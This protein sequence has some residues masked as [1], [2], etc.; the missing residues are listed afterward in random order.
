MY[1]SHAKTEKTRLYA[2]A[3]KKVPDEEFEEMKKEKQKMAFKKLKEKVSAHYL[4][5]GKICRVACKSLKKGLSNCFGLNVVKNKLDH[6][7]D[8]GESENENLVKKIKQIPLIGFLAKLFD[9]FAYGP[10]NFT[11]ECFSK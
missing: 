8:E 5:I 2:F 11:K 7:E 10:D 3:P 1:F 4:K 9:S 6:G